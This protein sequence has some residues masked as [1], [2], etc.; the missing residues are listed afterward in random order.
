MSFTNLFAIRFDANS[1][2]L[3]IQF[4]KKS[5]NNLNKE[6]NCFLF[7]LIIKRPDLP[8][9][10][11]STS[12]VVVNLIDNR[13][14]RPI[15][16]NIV[17]NFTIYENSPLDSL[18]G[19]VNAIYKKRKTISD[20]SDSLLDDSNQIKYRIVPNVLYDQFDFSSMQ[21]SNEN[22]DNNLV[23]SNNNNN[24]NNG[25][26]IEINQLNGVLTQ[27]LNIDREKYLNGDD[28][29][30][31][32]PKI[33][34]KNTWSSSSS[35]QL[36]R[37][38][39]NRNSDG[40]IKINIESSYLTSMSYGY[41]TVNI[42]I[43][44]I[45]DNA[46]LARIKPI[47][48]FGRLSKS[49][50]NLVYNQKE[51][52]EE[53]GSMAKANFYVNENTP[54]NQIIGYVG[55]YD[56]DAGENGTIKSIDLRLVK[57]RRP[58]KQN[59]NI[60]KSKYEKLKELEQRLKLNKINNS[61]SLVQIKSLIEYFTPSIELNFE[62]SE[63]R[64][65]L[66]INK[67][68][69]K[70]YTLQLINKLNFKEYE[71]FKI[72]LKIQDNGTIPQLESKT[73]IN[74]NVIETNNYAPIFISIDNLDND[75]EI[76]LNVEE[77]PLES[78]NL[79]KTNTK[80]NIEWP[81]LFKAFAIDFDDDKNGQIKY[82]IV[83]NPFLNLTN[84]NEK[85]AK[86]LL[87]TTFSLNE[88]TGELRLMRN[89]SR[90]LIDG[91]SLKLIIMAQDQCDQESNRL[92]ATL[93]LKIRVIDLNNNLP[94]FESDHFQFQFQI[95]N[96]TE[97]NEK[98]LNFQKIASSILITDLDTFETNSANFYNI[99]LNKT[100]D[101]IMIKS[102]ESI[103]G[104]TESFNKRMPKFIFRDEICLK[105]LSLFISDESSPF[106]FVFEAVDNDNK[107]IASV[108]CLMSIWLD[109]N[110]KEIKRKSDKFEFNLT[111][112]DNGLSRNSNQIDYSKPTSFS[113]DLIFLEENSNL[114]KSYSALN[115]TSENTYYLELN[116]NI[117][118]NMNYLTE[119]KFLLSGNEQ[120][121]L[122]SA[123]KLTETKSQKFASKQVTDKFKLDGSKLSL[124]DKDSEGV[125]LLD[126]NLIKENDTQELV[127]VDLIIHSQDNQEENQ[128][129]MLTLNNFKKDINDLL[130]KSMSFNNKNYFF[131]SEPT[132][133]NKSFISNLYDGSSL[134]RFQSL[135]FGSNGDSF[136][137]NLRQIPNGHMGLSR[138]LLS[139][140]TSLIQFV[141]VTLVISFV[142][143]VVF[144]CCLF[145]II[146]KNCSN[147]KK[148]KNDQSKLKVS[149]F[150]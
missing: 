54:V 100:S 88:H 111:L 56:P 59:F 104:E 107:S 103:I 97:S 128:N 78:S 105:T 36:N 46:P 120:I 86:R 109:V 67:I 81:V 83:N 39:P 75:N 24:I 108:K 31:F 7:D 18:I 76:K 69:E 87:E 37:I 124:S 58:S 131:D 57:L 122:K 114:Q 94:K 117:L 47:G 121:V 89:L 141:V 143:I 43:K 142:V 133:N 112:G 115:K 91:D 8:I 64:M 138:I 17:Y 77:S 98:S 53:D 61:K 62:T 16:E 136:I 132:D 150:F 73:L 92:N 51:N 40:L 119:F 11:S 63:L 80:S 6:I 12:T 23:S 135:L 5:Y 139:N 25:L 27:K 116:S 49:N 84:N 15:F 145:I 22:D 149:F 147:V 127:Q 70:L 45:N 60:R 129:H 44:D 140:R 2:K 82:T 106:L 118:K 95:V 65:P 42:F 26:P 9:S 4:N 32:E 90:D 137:S 96:T 1:E 29:Y 134:I 30:L 68:G 113:V 130:I 144:I 13:F 72:E 34:N 148:G 101:L 93:N 19:Q 21:F 3:F 85:D 48:N 33:Q 50:S 55:V 41:C 123:K 38:S 20:K 146:K 14:D 102:P 126:L 79:G 71:S 74:L 66:K 52:Q 110:N 10:Q 99:D 35:P 125:Y 28:Q